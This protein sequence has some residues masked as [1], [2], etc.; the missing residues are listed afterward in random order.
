MSTPQRSDAEPEI[1][2]PPKVATQQL[3]P[4]R[5]WR[6]ILMGGVVLLLLAAAGFFIAFRIGPWKP[7]EKISDLPEIPTV[8]LDGADPAIIRVVREARDVLENSPEVGPAWGQYAMVLQAHGFAS[9]AHT[10]YDTAIRLDSTNA[11]W[12]YLQGDLYHDGPGG[13]EAALP[14]FEQAASLSP[15]NSLAQLRVANTLLELGRLE[16]AQREFRTV[17]TVD[18]NDPQAQLG[19]GRLEM[20]RRQ[21]REALKFLEPVS[22][23][24]GVQNAACTMLANVYDRIGDRALADQMRQRLAK[25]PPDRNRNDDPALRVAGF[26]VGVGPEITTVERLMAQKQVQEAVDVAEG[27]VHRYPSSQEAWL[28]LSNAYQMAGDRAGS[29]RAARKCIELAP[30]NADA[31]LNLGNVLISQRRHREALEHVQKAIQLNP[32]KTLAYYSLGECRRGLGDNAGAAEAYKRAGIEP[33]QFRESTSPER[34]PEVPAALQKNV[35]VMTFFYTDPQP[36]KAQQVLADLISPENV[37]NPWYQERGVVLQLM[38]ANLG[39]IAFGHE[40]LIRHFESKFAAAPEMGK[41]IILRAL[42][43]CGDTTTA[44]VVEQWLSDTANA[45]IKME[46]TRLKE[47]LASSDRKRLRDAPANDPIDLDYLWG[48][49]FATG[50]YA[51]VSRIFDVFDLPNDPAHSELK[52]AAQYSAIT[53]IQQHPKLVDLLKKNL[54]ARSEGSK[55][56]ITEM[57][58]RLEMEQRKK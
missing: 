24:P 29:E 43:T 54:D 47:R 26:E 38:A 11:L 1:S 50:E 40:E 35:P 9:A 46:L 58:R 39:D 10:C 21:Y 19:M 28:A 53:N 15:P 6:R 56:M 52:Q 2:Q 44:Q 32:K 12:P 16:D 36:E 18:S 3:P 14:R 55:T 48:D 20:T 49:F 23:H 34:E 17:L 25:M 41:R 42:G 45:N 31:W 7:A 51:P 57:L 37:N 5:V 22:E 4:T 8:N 27:T 33:P 30:K 13:P